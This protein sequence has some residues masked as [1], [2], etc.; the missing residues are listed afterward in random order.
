[1]QKLYFWI[2][3]LLTVLC[4]AGCSDDEPKREESSFIKEIT[5]K[6]IEVKPIT[7][8]ENVITENIITEEIITEE[9]I[10]EEIK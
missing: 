3:V 6:P 2:V 9:I 4:L 8:K 10:T 1:M 7:I 5:V